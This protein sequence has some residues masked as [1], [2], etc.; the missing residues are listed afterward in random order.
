MDLLQLEISTSR[1]LLQPISMKYKE[2]IFS[3]FN[4]EITTYMY[5]KPP[6]YISETEDFIKDSLEEIKK[7][8]NLVL[9][10]L[11]K[12][13]FKFLGCT[14]IH[15]INS[16]DPELGIW[17]K[18]SAH[19]KGYGLES[20]IALKTWAEENL[21]FQYLV[22]CA[23]K[24]NIPSRRIPE[25]LGGKIIREYKKTNLS[26]KVLNILEYVLPKAGD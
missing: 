15:E 23:D 10:I 26:G 18:K 2:D 5:T 19:G 20:I 11:N 7:C 1:L 25:K 14:G 22:Y 3:E 21:D 24:A 13:S 4:Q 8:E 16:N 12:K 6:K 9:V 17:L